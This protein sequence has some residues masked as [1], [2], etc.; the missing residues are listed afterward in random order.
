MFNAALNQIPRE[1]W[2]FKPALSEWS[3]HEV[4]VHMADSESIG[5]LRVRTLIAD[6]GSTL[7][8]Y[9]GAVWALALN[10]RNQNADDALQSFRLTRQM[11]HHLLKTLPD[12]IF[13]HSVIHPVFDEPY[14][15]E[16]WL[17]IYTDHIP[18]HVG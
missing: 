11:T 5:A 9:D 8:P 15:F 3:N 1:A 7:M 6:P 12:E 16:Q 2:E 13:T 18:E 17:N 4:I 14:T 10:Y